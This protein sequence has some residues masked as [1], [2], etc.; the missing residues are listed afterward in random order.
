MMLGEDALQAD[1]PH[2]KAI[3]GVEL[4]ESSSMQVIG[5]YFVS[6]LLF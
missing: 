5:H 3:E 1:L 2:P 6:G 4:F